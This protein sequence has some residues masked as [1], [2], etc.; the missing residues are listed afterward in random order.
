MKKTA[1]GDLR[2]TCP[3]TRSLSLIIIAYD[4]KQ[5]EKENISR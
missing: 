4:P 1:L 2:G 5:N 3:I